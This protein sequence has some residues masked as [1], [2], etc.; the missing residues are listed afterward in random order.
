METGLV[1]YNYRY[2]SPELG[3]WLSRDPIEEQGGYNLY[4]ML[5]N[6]IVNNWDQWGYG[7]AWW[8][9]IAAYSWAMTGNWNATSEE[10]DA[11]HE[12]FGEGLTGEY[13]CDYWSDKFVENDLSLTVGVYTDYAYWGGSGFAFEFHSHPIGKEKVER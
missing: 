9:P 4:G 1:Y 10:L 8:C 6:G 2:Y 12:G 5:G 7:H 13:Y 11:A 3:R